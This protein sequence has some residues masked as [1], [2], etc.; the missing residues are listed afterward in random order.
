MSGRKMERARGEGWGKETNKGV[1]IKLFCFVLLLPTG[2]QA[3]TQQYSF[4]NFSGS[5]H[6]CL[7]YPSLT[8][9]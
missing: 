3:A 9:F 6:L 8:L 2:L 1:E 5:L 4:L 7:S